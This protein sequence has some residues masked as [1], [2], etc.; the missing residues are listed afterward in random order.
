MT[1]DNRKLVTQLPDAAVV[2]DAEGQVGAGNHAAVQLF[3]RDPGGLALSDLFSPHVPPGEAAP[4]QTSRRW[5]VEGIRADGVPFIADASELTAGADVRILLLRRLE[6]AALVGETERFLA[7]AFDLA[8]IGM[9]F[10]NPDGQYVRVNPAL[11]RLLGRSADELLGRRDQ[12]FTHP[13]DRQ[14]DVD[15]AWRILRG[16][17]DSWQTEK[18]FVCPEGSTI[19]V[20]ANMSFLRDDEGRAL[21]WLG[22]FQDITQRKSLEAQLRRQADE[23]PLTSL[24]N[25][26][27][28]ER[29]VAAALELSTR[30]GTHGAL[31]LVDLDGFKTVNDT[32]GHAVGDATLC[33]V[34]AAMRSRLRSTDVLARVG[35]D[36]FAILLPLTGRHR[37][38]RVA[39]ALHTEIAGL[40]LG[41]G[42]PRLN[43]RASIGIAQIGGPDPPMSPDELLA[44][45]DAAMYAHKRGATGAG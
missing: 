37:A 11:C 2:V 8:P 16:E 24:P 1:P 10:F 5:R 4:D 45:A 18:R 25:R 32:Y 26:R 39:D 31:L 36:E 42:Q 28:F 27:M 44:A 40:D 22:Q 33:A 17:I 34:A 35:G 20:I 21:A 41:A 13:D 30:H 29:E 14:S 7:A 15:A 3:G 43:L 19:W 12:E 6:P 23:D 38:H 9:A